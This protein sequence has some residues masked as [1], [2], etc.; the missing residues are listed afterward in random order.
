[1]S[2]QQPFMIGHFDASSITPLTMTNLAALK[3]VRPLNVERT[4]RAMATA[5]P[6]VQQHLRL[7]EDHLFCMG[8]GV[9]TRENVLQ[10]AFEFATEH[11]CIVIGDMGKV[12]FPPDAVEEQ[13][14]AWTKLVVT[15]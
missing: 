9:R 10:F 3:P 1:M 4:M 7:R 14:L 5:D 15:S 12:L 8:Q 13:M 6:A 11:N 2:R